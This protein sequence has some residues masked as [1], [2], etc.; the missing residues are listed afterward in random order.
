MRIIDLPSLS[1][2]LVKIMQQHLT[3]QAED[4]SC[5]ARGGPPRVAVVGNL[6]RDVVDGGAPT[7]GGCPRFAAQAFGL[8]GR[9][10]QIVTRFRDGDEGLFADVVAAPGV[11]VNV[12]RA[13]ATSGFSLDYAGDQR[14]VAVTAVGETWRPEDALA[15]AAGVE[16]VHVAPLLRSDFPVETLAALAHGRRLS[17]DGQGLVRVP[18]VGPL[19]LDAAYDPAALRHVTALKLS[20]EEAAVV[21][22][23]AF[24][25]AAAARLG[26][27]EVLLT[28]GSR[29]SVVFAAGAAATFVPPAG[30]VLGVQATGAGDAFM[31]GYASSRADGA[32]PVEAAQRASR[33]VAELL[34]ARRSG[35]GTV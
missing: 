1:M 29:G 3:T 18:A 6:A 31:V 34:Q 8:L 20:E 26:V 25:D 24:D 7:A 16:W 28:L 17:L 11:S 13:S 33:L 27:P 14:E 12:L 2:S 30:P 21:S 5:P 15:L 19:V 23:G 22:G 10:G 4:V 35:G 32:A 9:R